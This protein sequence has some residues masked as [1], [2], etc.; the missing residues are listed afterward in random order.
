MTIAQNIGHWGFVPTLI[1]DR[2][3]NPTTIAI[4]V[5]KFL[6]KGRKLN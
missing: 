6:R 2:Y 3:I 4:W 1:F 5:A